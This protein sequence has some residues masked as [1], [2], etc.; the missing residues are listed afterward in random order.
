[1]AQCYKK[2]NFKKFSDGRGDLIP[3]EFGENFP[4][5]DIP[6]DVKRCFFISP[7]Y[8]EI[9]ACHAHRWVEQVIICLEGS[10]DLVL[11]DGK[12]NECTIT[13]NDYLTGIHIQS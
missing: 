9:R 10:F 11:K 5:A 12:G 8:D 2:I 3:L 13:M 1:M 7:K 4:N 6:F